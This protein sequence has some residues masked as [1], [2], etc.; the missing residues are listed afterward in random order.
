MICWPW[1]V[2]EFSASRECDEAVSGGLIF[3]DTAAFSSQSQEL[4]SRSVQ[5]LHAGP[6]SP[7]ANLLFVESQRGTHVLMPEQSLSYGSIAICNFAI[8]GTDLLSRTHCGPPECCLSNPSGL[9]TP[10]GENSLLAPGN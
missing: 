8:A 10:I 6:Q 4:V 3:S 1:P 7:G 9:H 5:E 2:I